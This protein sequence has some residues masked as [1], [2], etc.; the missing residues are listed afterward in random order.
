MTDNSKRFQFTSY[1]TFECHGSGAKALFGGD[2]KNN[3]LQRDISYSHGSWITIDRK[4]YQ[5]GMCRTLT[6]NDENSHNFHAC[7]ILT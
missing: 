2:K 3:V 5:R 7:E 4:L 6:K 1:H